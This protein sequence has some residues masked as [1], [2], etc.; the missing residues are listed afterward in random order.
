MDPTVNRQF[1]LKSRPLGLPTPEEVPMIESPVPVAGDGEIVIRNLFLSLDPAIRGWMSDE[2]NYMDPIPVGAKIWSG[3]I[4]RVVQSNSPDFAVGDIAMGMNGWEDYT[5]C[6]AGEANKVDPMGMPL[7]LFMSVLGA[8][9]LTAYFG[10]LE[11]GKPQ[12]GET[13]LVSGAAGAVG[14][15]AGQ[16]GKIKGCRVVGIAGSEAKCQWLLDDCGFDAVINYRATDDLAAAIREKCPD[17]VDIYW[18][19]VGGDMLD[20]ALLNLAERARIVICG[21]ISTYN[22]ETKRPGP[23][24]LWQLLVKSARMEGFVVSNYLDRFPEGVM[25]L[26]EWL[27]AGKLQYK[28]HVVDGLENTLDA[29]HMLFDGRNTGKLIIKVADE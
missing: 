16:I 2:P 17:G 5:L 24:N 18:D 27:Q 12:P 3:G 23:K 9:G 7:T 14:S 1:I 4:G 11:V 22:D 20:A 26:A 19:N 21:W 13:L 6:A 8:T 25:A 15:I 10:L 28:E 29:F